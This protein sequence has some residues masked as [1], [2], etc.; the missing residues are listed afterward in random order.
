[1]SRS[2]SSWLSV[3]AG[4]LL[5]IPFVA[6]ACSTAWGNLHLAYGDW[7]AV[8]V[9]LGLSSLSTALIVCLGTPLA[10]W[11]ARTSSRARTGVEALVLVSLLTPPLAMGIL[12]V[13]AYGPYGTLGTGLASL[14]VT[15]TNNI[16]AFVLAQLYGGMAYYVLCAR[17]AFGAVP[18]SIEEAARGLGC[19]PLQVFW[20]V[21]LA[22]V[23]RELASALAIVWVR[24]I[25]EFGIVMVFAYFP[26]GI[27]VKLFVNLQNEGVDAVYALVWLLLVVTLPF[28][29]WCLAVGQRGGVWRGEGVR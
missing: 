22:V 2:R 19:S 18:P 11:L 1:M 7:T 8:G 24:V 27:P 17:S 16:P 3:P 13:T 25:G 20:R 21:T 29:L 15:L 14:G 10:L 28:P 26:Q 12:L 9:S 6:L 4:L 23:R 5:I